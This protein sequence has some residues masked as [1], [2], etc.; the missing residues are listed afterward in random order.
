MS[1]ST[2]EKN[3]VN[4]DNWL[5]EAKTASF[6]QNSYISQEEG[7][8]VM[9]YEGIAEK[10]HKLLDTNK[11]SEH[12]ENSQKK[13]YVQITE[14]KDLKEIMLPLKL[15]ELQELQNNDTYCRDIAKK[16]HKDVE[17]QKILINQRG[18]LHRLWIEDGRTFK[19]ILVP[20]VLQDSMVILAHDYSGHNGSRRTYNCLK[21]QYYWSG[22]RK[23]VFRHCK[24]CT[25]CILQ[26]QGQAEKGFSHFESP[27][28][29]M[30]FICMD[31]V[32]PIHP[33][34]S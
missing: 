23:Q 9:N 21:K 28:L 5:A 30:E 29:P 19:C 6:S 12:S 4:Q 16:L 17:L 14:D 31:L 8:V 13:T 3:Y 22:M 18:V 1:S 11:L 7:T 25:E 33:P 24:K 27:D 10:K 15:R 32:G 20:K 2:V 34:S 26:N